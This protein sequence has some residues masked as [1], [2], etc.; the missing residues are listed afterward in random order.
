MGVKKNSDVVGK[1]KWREKNGGEIL[2]GKNGGEILAGKNG[3]KI[4]AG[5]NTCFCSSSFSHRLV[6]RTGHNWRA[7]G[8]F[9]LSFSFH[10]AFIQL[11][12][13]FLSA[14]DFRALFSNS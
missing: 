5:K 3:G 14:F 10:S 11:S 8:L 7:R 13:S 2:A 12:F 6:L 1:K 4:L 9:Q